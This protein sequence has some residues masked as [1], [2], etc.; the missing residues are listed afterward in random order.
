ANSGRWFERAYA[1]ANHTFFAITALLSGQSCERMLA[2]SEAKPDGALRY[3]FWLP[4]RLHTLGYK[5]IA[6]R[7]PLV[8]SGKLRPED[9]KF[10]A[11]DFGTD[12]FGQKHRG[13]TS[14]QVVDSVITFLRENKEPSPLFAWIHFMDPHAVHEAHVRF[15][16]GTLADRYDN[17]LS[18]VDFNLARLL[19]EIEAEYGDDALVIIT[20]DHG[21]ALGD[22]RNYGHGF[23]LREPEIRVPLVMRGPGIDPGVE[24]R[25]VSALGVVPTILE[26][27]GDTPPPHRLSYPSLL[28][29]NLPPPVAHNPEYLWNESRMESA[30][31]VG[32]WK[33]IHSR[34]RNTSLLFNLEDDPEE[35][36]NRI[37]TA[38]PGAPTLDNL[39]AALEVFR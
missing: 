10:D 14:K 7:P 34:V 28:Q 39:K 26:V 21:E 5:S 22:H 19:R 37:G 29:N 12:D 27:L 32:E 18:W 30:I 38:A 13:T 15:P 11:I 3:T 33:L 20:A 6:F 23:S 8:V 1:P 31:I 4:Q 9:L 2:P 35:S 24:R 16:G 36:I 25:P 17:E